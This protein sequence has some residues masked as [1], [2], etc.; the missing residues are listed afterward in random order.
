V[1]NI[2]RDRRFNRFAWF[3]C[4]PHSGTRSAPARIAASSA[5]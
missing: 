5:P 1:G 2:R 3:G 4:R